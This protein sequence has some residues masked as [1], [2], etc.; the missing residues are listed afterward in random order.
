MSSPAAGERQTR[1]IRPCQ[2]FEGHTKWVN[3]VIHLPDRQRIMTCS[4]D[5][6]LRVWNLKSGKQI[7]DDWREGES[8]LWDIALSPDGKK[9]ISGSQDGVV[10]LWDMDAGKAV[11]KW[12]GHT[13]VAASV[14]WNQDGGRVLSGS[15]DGTARVWDVKRGET[16]LAIRTGLSMS[17]VIY[18]PDETMIA[19]GGGSEEKEEYIKIFDANTG[20]L[21]SN[22]KG[23]THRVHCLAWT[24]D[25]TTLISCSFDS[26][27][28]TWNTTTW[29]QINVLAGHTSHV[30]AIAISP[31]ARILASASIDKTARLWNLGDGHPIGSPLEHTRALNCVSFS[32][33]G[34]LLATG[35]WDNNAY[36]WDVSVI[37]REA[38]LDE[39]LLNPNDGHKSLLEADAT[40]RPVQRRRRD[41]I[42]P[43]RPL[44][45]GFFDDS[46]RH[47]PPSR[48]LSLSPRGHHAVGYLSSDGR[49]LLDRLS[50]FRF[51][52]YNT[53]GATPRARLLEWVGNPFSRTPHRHDE[54]IELQDPV[55]DVPLA[56]GNPRNYSAREVR[57]KQKQ[58]QEKAKIVK[59]KEKEKARDTKNAKNASVGSSL[60][61]QRS[62]TRQSGRADQAQSSS[63]SEHHTAAPIPPT[64]PA[65]A[66][67]PTTRWTRFWLA[68]CCPE[69]PEH[70]PA[71][72]D[73]P[74]THGKPGN[75]S[76][77][78]VRMKKEKEKARKAK[79]HLTG[80][81]RPPQNN[82]AQQSSGAAPT[83]SSSVLHATVS[84][85]STMP[86]VTTT[87]ANNT[88]MTLRPDVIITQA[89]RCFSVVHLLS[90]PMVIIF[91]CSSNSVCCF[92]NLPILMSHWRALLTPATQIC[93]K[94]HIFEHRSSLSV[95][96]LHVSFVIFEL[97]ILQ[98]IFGVVGSLQTLSLQ[99][100]AHK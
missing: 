40:R 1:S 9:V 22:L 56:Q 55:V 100:L 72:V 75:V 3:G 65:V 68:A 51:N 30:K 4:E 41:N 16:I 34:K 83:Q 17:S 47:P 48:R 18:S 10:R 62:I 28:R 36:T 97:F 21:I 23:H 80:T 35:C 42:N 64:A 8:E 38:G 93:F 85:P 13:S 94:N 39:L 27:I 24:A 92:D 98:C 91:L 54:G 45:P 59:E 50:L 19:T 52:H 53:Q 26:S 43:D 67:V 78:E 14:C 63:S 7:E 88:P 69:L 46:P 5:G 99:N 29:Q 2:K 79:N 84:T 76:A 11:T 73:V 32:S 95:P 31:N 82:I 44:P 58:E 77:G 74:L 37:V 90:I 60:L 6:S 15:F 25:G 49:T 57:R 61:H 89:G 81:S 87:S 12:T 70:R 96:P 20:K 71:V 33:D 86:V 66:S